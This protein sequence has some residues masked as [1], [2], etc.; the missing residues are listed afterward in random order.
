MF[1][2]WRLLEPSPQVLLLKNLHRTQEEPFYCKITNP[3]NLYRTTEEPF[4]ELFSNVQNKLLTTAH[5]F[6]ATVPHSTLSTFTHPT[7]P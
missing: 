5:Y 3:T 7:K 2:E 4:E 6:P 1:I